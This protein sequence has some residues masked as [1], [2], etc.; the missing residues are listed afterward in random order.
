MERVELQLYALTSTLDGG[1]QLP[2]PGRLTFRRKNSRYQWLGVW[3]DLE[4]DLDILFTY[5]LIYLL[6]YSMERSPPWEVNR[7]SAS[8]EI[9]RI[10]WNLNVHYRIHKCPPPVPVLSQLILKFCRTENTYTSAKHLTTIHRASAPSLV[11][12]PTA[13]SLLLYTMWL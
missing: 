7:F 12:T 2:G 9:H 5:L 3:V 11:T 6:T 10:S 8:Q 1:G 13:L 4:V